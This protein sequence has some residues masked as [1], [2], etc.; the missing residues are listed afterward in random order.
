MTDPRYRSRI[1]WNHLPAAS[2]SLSWGQKPRICSLKTPDQTLTTPRQEDW[3]STL[4]PHRLETFPQQSDTSRL[5]LRV[6]FHHSPVEDLINFAACL[7]KITDLP[8]YNCAFRARNLQ[9][10]GSNGRSWGV[11]LFL[12]NLS[13]SKL[14]VPV[15]VCMKTSETDL[16]RGTS[17]PR[18]LGRDWNSK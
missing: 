13:C 11:S 9:D 16:W 15:S 3:R 17:A 7:T 18:G 14:Q 5:R 6:P 4:Y 10:V 2:S 12:C 1:L 8:K